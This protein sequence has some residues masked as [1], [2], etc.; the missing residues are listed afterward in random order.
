ML[1][2]LPLIL[3]LV[4]QAIGG[5]AVTLAHARDVVA[6]PGSVEASHDGRCAILHDEL[7]CALC[8]YASARV[9]TP[10]TFTIVTPAAT[11]R[12]TRLE[13]IASVV[14]VTRRAPPARAPPSL[15]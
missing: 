12:F 3:L 7:R 4:G 6:A 14:S 2:R 15:L 13:P 8:H 11:I 5:G 9:V 10:Q 1:K